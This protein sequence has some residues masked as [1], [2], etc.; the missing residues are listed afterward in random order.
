MTAT[1]RI[2]LVDQPEDVVSQ[3]REA[4]AADG[5]AVEATAD[6]E[7]ALVAARD[8][9]IRLL[10]ADWP[11]RGAHGLLARVR[12]ERLPVGVIMLSA[13]TV[14]AQAVEAM[15]AGAD[16]VLTRP[17]D[18][19][20]LRIRVA[21]VIER[22]MLLDEVEQLRRHVRSDYGFHQLISKSPAM[23]KVFALIE[24]VGA[25]GSTVLI[26]GETGTG[27]E[28]VARAIHDVSPRHG[29]PWVAVNCAALPESLLE[30]ELFGH[31]R[32]A[33]TGAD[34]RRTGR[35][36]AADGGT[37]FL[38]EIGEMTPPMQVR[39]LRVLQTGQFERVGGNETLKVDVRIV[40]AT[41]RPLDA[42]VAQ[43]RFRLDLL[44][45]LRVVQV[46]L[47]PL[48][49]RKEDIPLL[50]PHFLDLL[51]AKSNP[52]V[53]EID[54]EAM[55][56]LLDHD[57]PGNVRELENA[58]KSAVALADGT[59][60]RRG[61]LPASVAPPVIHAAGAAPLVDVNRT[62]PD[63][64]ADL[65]GQVERE[66]FAQMLARYRGNIARCARHSGLTRRGLVL[67][68]RRLGLDQREFRLPGGRREPDL[69][70]LDEPADDRGGADP[71][72]PQG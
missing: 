22:R 67:K 18:P 60:I 50:V 2:L 65:V 12:A 23:R 21:R 29:R 35:F 5:L 64:T 42:A 63:L 33:F 8:G 71:A 25:F 31:E 55:Q 61:D 58:I 4:L 44:H 70:T 45:R 34:R 13:G 66:Y 51:R 68:L 19:E 37:L 48:R 3:V 30:S 43:G 16:D 26:Q 24:R 11:A 14:A 62:L 59:I 7:A 27:K 38:D 49:E 39:L 15:K 69:A 6:H 20:R 32:G 54:H 17:L 36:E 47:P 28:L 56:T 57:W 72:I 10:L 9:R 53:T 41:N 52:P 40:A 1:R 46:D